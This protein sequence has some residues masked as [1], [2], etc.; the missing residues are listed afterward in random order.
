MNRRALT[1][2][3]DLTGVLTI[4]AAVPYEKELVS[5]FP[6]AWTPYIVAVGA[7]ATVGLRI[8]KA[9]LPVP[10]QPVSP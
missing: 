6:P 5:L 1:I 8:L 10:A 2:L 9:F 3:S 7:I 4:L